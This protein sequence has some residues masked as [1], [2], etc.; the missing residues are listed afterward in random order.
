MPHTTKQILAQFRS[1]SPYPVSPFFD[2]PKEV[3]QQLSTEELTRVKKHTCSMQVLVKVEY[4]RLKRKAIEN[5][6]IV[7]NPNSNHE[8]SHF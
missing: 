3:I 5:M 2:F 1:G 8:T 4:E 7:Q 6:P